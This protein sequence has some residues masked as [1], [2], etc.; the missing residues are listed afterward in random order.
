MNLNIIDARAIPGDSAFLI[1][2]GRTSVLC[3]TGFGF[4]GERVT[5][6]VRDALGERPLDY[7]FLTHS[8]YDHIMGV[9]HL[10]GAY[11]NAKVVAGAYAARIF[12]KPSARAV[13]CD[14]DRK[15]ADTCGVGAYE[16][17][18][19]R[20]RVDVALEDGD[21]IM[22]GEMRFVAVALPGHTKCSFGFY[23]PD[24][25]LLIGSETLGVYD[26]GDILFPNCLVGYQMALDSIAKAKALDVEQLL[27]PHYGLLSPEK[28]AYYFDRAAAATTETAEAIVAILRDGGDKEDVIAWFTEK[29]YHGDI[30][31]SYPID[32]M[33]LNTSILADRFA[34]EFG[35]TP[36]E[37]KR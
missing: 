27:V 34:L 22:A 31:I 10:L 12:E 32:A 16:T 4:T 30:R 24:H 8:H 15:F 13:M 23:L 26:G 20:L 35:L 6:K 3:D 14:L 1:D 9:P 7:I 21:E 11:P 33:R 19:D 36:K 18:M 29:F 28:T 17:H 2:D 5:E 25:K 37:D